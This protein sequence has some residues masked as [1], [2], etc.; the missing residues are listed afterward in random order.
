ML[1][2]LDFC[3]LSSAANKSSYFDDLWSLSAEYLTHVAKPFETNASAT[4][5]PPV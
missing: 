1:P 3:A 2:L 4:L 5:A